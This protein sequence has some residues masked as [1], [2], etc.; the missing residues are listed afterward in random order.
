[1]EKLFF[2]LDDCS[3]FTFLQPFF[4]QQFVEHDVCMLKFNLSGWIFNYLDGYSIYLDA[5]ITLKLGW[6]GQGEQKI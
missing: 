2:W 1:M 4:W 5:K 6:G 3:C